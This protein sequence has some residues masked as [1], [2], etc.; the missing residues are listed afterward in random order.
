MSTPPAIS[1]LAC[2]CRG[3]WN[4]I[5][6]MPI[7][8]PGPTL[9]PPK[10]PSVAFPGAFPAKAFVA[11]LPTQVRASILALFGGAVMVYGTLRR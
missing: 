4:V 1:W 10:L 5:S 11:R 7:R 3:A 6:D 2:V 9:V 8:W